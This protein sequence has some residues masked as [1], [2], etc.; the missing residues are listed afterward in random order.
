MKQAGLSGLI[1]VG[2]HLGFIAAWDK[3]NAPSTLFIIAWAHLK[4]ID[5]SDFTM[6]KQVNDTADWAT[7]TTTWAWMASHTTAGGLVGC[8][9]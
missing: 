6:P 2:M 1:P 5:L 8:Y 3:V 9:F 4:S 7:Q